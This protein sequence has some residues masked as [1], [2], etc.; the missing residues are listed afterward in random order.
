MK[1]TLKK[2]V[3]N[4]RLSEETTNFSADICIDGKVVGYAANHGHGGSTDIVA[5]YGKSEELSKA[6]AFCKAMGHVE[7]YPSIPMDL[8][9][10]V[11]DLLDKHEKAKFDAAYAKKLAKDMLKGILCKTANGYEIINWVG[12]DIPKLLSTPQGVKVLTAKVNQLVGEGKVI[13]NTN[14]P[15]EYLA[16]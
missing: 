16:V 2:I 3:I 1:I 11:D 10:Y 6:E 8:E 14:L 9:C 13:L 5:N 15:K 4:E 7:G 12:N